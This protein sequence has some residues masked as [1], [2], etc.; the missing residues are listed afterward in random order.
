M[1]ASYDTGQ[2]EIVGP[3]GRIFLYTHETASD[4]INVVSDV[5]C[6]VVRWDDPDYL[7]RMI[8][9]RMIPKNKWNDELGFGIGT[10]MYKDVNILVTLDTVHNTVKIS[11]YF[12]TSA[13]R[14]VSMS[15]A[16]FIN[17]YAD[18]ANL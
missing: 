3:Y 14:G 7:A 13:I 10:Q 12:D 5:L 17:K 11:S 15:F 18:N 1:E 4:L 16:D 8:F 9:C 6:R 2:I